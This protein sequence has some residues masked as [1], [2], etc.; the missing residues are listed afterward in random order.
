MEIELKYQVNEEF[1]RDRLLEDSYITE[2][3]SGEEEVL[4][5]RAAYF[6]TEDKALKA[7]KIT[8]RVRKENE[9]TIATIK[10]DGNSKNGLHI[11]NELNLN[12]PEEFYEKPDP[13]VFTGSEIMPKL[14]KAWAGKELLPVMHMEYV[15]H[16]ILVDTGKCICEVSVDNGL[17]RTAKGDAE[18]SEMEIELYSGDQEDMLT[19]GERLKNKYNLE[20]SDVSKYKRGLKILEK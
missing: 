8:F 9:K 14:E 6:D 18:I 19:F 1:T 11:R 2:K 5:M 7:A 4:D 13:T 15:R 16:Q 12:V 17:I 20:P 10:W 3:A